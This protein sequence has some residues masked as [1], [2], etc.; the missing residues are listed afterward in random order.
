MTTDSHPCLAILL[1]QPH[2]PWPT[3]S[4]TSDSPPPSITLPKIISFGKDSHSLLFHFLFDMSHSQFRHHTT[5]HFHKQH[6]LHK[7]LHNSPTSHRDILAVTYNF[8]TYEYQLP[9]PLPFITMIPPA[10]IRSPKGVLLPPPE[11]TPNLPSPAASLAA[12]FIKHPPPQPSPTLLKLIHNY[13]TEY[14]RLNPPD[15][16]LPPPPPPQ[17]DNESHCLTQLTG[18]FSSLTPPPLILTSLYLNTPTPVHH[19][20]EYDAVIVTPDDHVVIAVVECKVSFPYK[21]VSKKVAGLS[22]I[23]PCTAGMF[24]DKANTGLYSAV[25]LPSHPVPL[26]Y[27]ADR[28]TYAT[29]IDVITTVSSWVKTSPQNIEA[30]TVSCED[31]RRD[32]VRGW[33]PSLVVDVQSIEDEVLHERL[34]GIDTRV[35]IDERFPFQGVLETTELTT[36]LL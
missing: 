8:F 9:L 30:C 18:L 10:M 19:T 11:S 17:S 29:G 25:T 14:D 7:L 13:C 16:I 2:H 15:A 31:A 22:L 4:A 32:A 27:M 23:P 34:R 24:K 5:T 12:Y 1:S 33:Q 26:F 20:T 6:T 3:R 36:A 21:D 28:V 35:L